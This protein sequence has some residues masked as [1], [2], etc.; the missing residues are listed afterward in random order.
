MM[1]LV[2]IYIAVSLLTCVIFY[3]TLRRKQG[4]LSLVDIFLIPIAS[5]IP[6]LGQSLTLY[7]LAELNDWE[8]KRF[9]VVTK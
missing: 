9:F 2:L 3:K 1:T 5:V 6:F 7:L 4:Y 8:N